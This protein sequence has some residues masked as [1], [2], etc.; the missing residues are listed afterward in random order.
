MLGVEVG[1]DL[2]VERQP[3]KTGGGQYDAVEVPLFYSGQAGVDVAADVGKPQVRA[4]RRQLGDAPGAAGAQQS[5]FGEVIDP[6]PMDPVHWLARDQD[7]PNVGPFRSGHELEIRMGLGGQI[8]QTVNRQVDA[9]VEEGP[10]DL[11][12][13]QA[14]SADFAQARPVYVAAGADR[15]E[16]D[17]EAVS[18][19]QFR[20]QVAD[21]PGL[22]RGQPAAAGADD[23]GVGAI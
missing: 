2:L 23:E 12:G 21:K 5:P 1:A 15:F 10:I 11:G 3:V 16:D 20:E 19:V 7:I 9:A 4:H 22:G 13:E 18:P 14:L 8:F 17:L 6:I